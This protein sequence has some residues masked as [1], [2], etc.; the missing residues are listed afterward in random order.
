MVVVLGEVPLVRTTLNAW[1]DRLPNDCDAISCWNDLFV[2][3]VVGLLLFLLF[4]SISI[5]SILI[6]IVYCCCC[7]LLFNGVVVIC[8]CALGVCFCLLKASK[9]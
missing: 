5:I 9:P 4:I 3:W 8:I 6:I 2:W 1:R 7:L